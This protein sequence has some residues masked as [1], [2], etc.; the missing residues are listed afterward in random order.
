[1]GWD[2]DAARRH[3][4]W[5]QVD[6]EGKLAERHP[7][8]DFGWRSLCLASPYASYV[9]KQTREILENYEVDGVMF[10]IVR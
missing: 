5:V 10:D 3:N 7:L 8:R 6:K 2:E 4:D 1:M 9:E